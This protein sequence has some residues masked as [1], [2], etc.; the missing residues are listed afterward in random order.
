MMTQDEI[1]SIRKSFRLLE[2]KIELVTMLFFNRLFRLDP[3][4]RLLSDDL[5]EQRKMLMDAM[6]A[7]NASLDG[8]PTV[9]PTLQDIGKRYAKSGVRTG[10]YCTVATALLQALEEFAGPRFDRVLH[11]AWTKLLGLVSGEI[12]QGATEAKAVPAGT[13][14]AVPKTLS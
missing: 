1:Q 10:D 14:V 7:L 13:G 3:S 9:R 5:T 12:L 11:R 2:G 4:L 6:L 8:F